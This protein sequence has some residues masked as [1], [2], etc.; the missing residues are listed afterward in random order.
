MKKT[1][2]FLVL[3]AVLSL[4]GCKKPGCTDPD[5]VNYNDKAKKD[6]GTCTY[7]G[8]MN[9]WYGSATATE[10]VNDGAVT[11][12]Y[13]VDGISIGSSAA[14]ISWP[15][16][17]SCDQTPPVNVVKDLGGQSTQAYSYSV[18]D[19]TGWEYWAGTVNFN[20][21]ECLNLELTW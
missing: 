2:L 19:Q 9:F 10:L 18:Q 17:P 8:S 12:T 5:A 20:A 1:A 4:P 11:L 6:D 14:S 21:N 13:Y 16:A 3:L 15:S 7:E